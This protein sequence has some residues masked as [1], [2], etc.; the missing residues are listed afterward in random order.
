MSEAVFDVPS[1][2]DVFLAQRDQPILVER[3]KAG[4]AHAH[5]AIMRGALWRMRRSAMTFEERR[6]ELEADMITTR[7][8]AARWL[9]A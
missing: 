5:I 2:S 6:A 4:T 1:S 7:R 8:C 9:R 3:L